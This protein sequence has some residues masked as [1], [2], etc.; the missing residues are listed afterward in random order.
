M[1]EEDDDMDEV[2]TSGEHDRGRSRYSSQRA[3]TSSSETVTDDPEQ[4]TASIARS[5]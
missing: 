5:L 1:G 2:F 4:P 3:A